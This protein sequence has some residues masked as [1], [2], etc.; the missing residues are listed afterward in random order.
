VTALRIWFRRLMPALRF[1]LGVALLHYVV[2][3]TGGWRAAS[4]FLTAWWLLPLAASTPFAGAAIEALR[5]RTLFRAQGVGLTTGRAYRLV[6]VGTLFNFALPGGTGGDVMKLY[7]LVT[8]NRGKGV[9]VA[10]VLA[11]DRILALGSLLLT[12]LILASF[13]LDLLR[14][15]QLVRVLVAAAVGALLVLIA[16]I[17]ISWSDTLRTTRLYHYLVERSPGRVTLRRVTDA[18]YQFRSHASAVLAAVGLSALGH[19]LL[20]CVFM[21]VGSVLIQAAAPTTTAL[22]ALLGMFANAVP[23]TPGG[24][25]VGEAAFDRLFALAGYSGGALVVLAWRLGM[26]PLSVAGFA[27]YVGGL[28]QPEPGRAPAMRTSS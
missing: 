18:L 3:A 24:L 12:L 23:I 26:I 7:Y 6:A 27:W 5:L 14:S 2:T 16:G 11:V 15:Y 22:L 21:A 4:R 20:V 17:A 19:L 13:N 25:G 1:L 8:D 28:S 10:T 9:E